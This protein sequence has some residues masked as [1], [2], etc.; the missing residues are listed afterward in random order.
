MTAYDFRLALLSLR[1]SPGLTALMVLAIAFGIAVCTISFAVYHAVSTNP[2]P[3][4]NDRLFAVTLDTWDVQQPHDRTRPELP[5][6]Q[7]TYRDITALGQSDIPLRTVMMFKTDRVLDSGLQGRKAFHGILRA[8]TGSF[9]PV[10]DVPFLYGAGWDE[11]ADANA[12]PVVVLSKESNEKVFGGENSVGRMIAIGG[13]EMRVVGV[14]NDWL[15]SPKF[16]DLNNGPFNN[17]E[18]AYVPFRF[19]I[20][21]EFGQIGNTN[22]WKNERIE[23]RADFLNSECVWLQLWAEL[24]T[25]ADRDRFQAYLDNYARSQKALGRME[26]PLNNHLYN[27]DQWL[28]FNEVVQKDNR[29]L[30]GIAMLFLAACLVNVVGLL[31]SKFLNGA[32]MTGLRR[33]LGASRRDVVRQ[34]IAEVLL[35]G[36]AGGLIGLVLASFGMAGIRALY[37]PDSI[38]I[39][40]L[41]QID[42]VVAGSALGLSLVA[43]MLAGLYPAWRIGRTSPAVYLKTQ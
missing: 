4:K 29:V 5:P 42:W 30:I 19:A 28:D 36:A 34:H 38:A 26:R 33:A 21:R 2:I 3:W 7:L 39:E 23:S 40:R 10:F 1:R 41:T 14:L 37:G 16:Y 17:P 25:R 12:D 15:P 6:P 24:P 22:C 18:D 11:S 20:D 35:L 31:L 8:T 9:F 13:H 32:A 43:G 27:V